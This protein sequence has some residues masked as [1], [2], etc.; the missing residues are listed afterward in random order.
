MKYDGT[1]IPGSPF[2][3]TS[4]PTLDD[5]TEEDSIQDYASNSESGNRDGE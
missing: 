1:D 3:M 5:V 4:N 2:E